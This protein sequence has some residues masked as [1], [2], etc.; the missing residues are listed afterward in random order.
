[1]IRKALVSDY[2]RLAEIHVFGWRCAY[3]DF[4]PIEYLINKMIVKFREDKWHKILTEIDDSN[5]TYVYEENNII[6][7]IMTI[8]DC[9]DEYRTDKTFELWSLYIDPLFQRKNIGMK[10]MEFCKKEAKNKG[11]QEI[12]LWVFEKNINAIK[13]YTKIG[14]IFDGR[15]NFLNEINENELRFKLKI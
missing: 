12:V 11:K 3:K 4:I 2:C 13:F 9:R 5:K 1:M 14:Y 15:K 7:G 8:G 6:K 10:F